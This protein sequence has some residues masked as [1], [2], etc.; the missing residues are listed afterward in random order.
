MITMEMFGK[1]RRMYFRDKLSLHEISKRTS[2]S[3]NTIRKWL[4]EILRGQ[5]R[6]RTAEEKSLANLPRLMMCWNNPSRLMRTVQDAGTQGQRR[7]A[8]RAQGQV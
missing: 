4:R 5:R 2:L 8:G 7:D 6:Q 3:R 1:I